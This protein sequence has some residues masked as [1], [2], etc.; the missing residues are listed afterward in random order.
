MD[1]FNALQVFVRVVE[2]G[3]FTRAAAILQLSKTTVTQ[4]VQQLEARLGV[5]LLQRTTRRVRVT[6]EGQAYYERITQVLAD[7]AQADTA[8]AQADTALR[9]RLRVDMP[10]PLAVLLV[11]PAL[12]QFQ[13][14]YPGIALELGVSD[15][16]IELMH[17]RVDCIVRGGVLQDSSLIAQR[18]ATLP[19][20]LYAAPSYLARHGAVL[21]PQDLATGAHQ[22]VGFMATH[23]GKVPLLHMQQGERQ[24]RV[25]A[26]GSLAVDDG[27]AC[28]AAL[29]AGLGI[30]ALPQYIVAPH[31]QSGALQPVL[32]DW[33]LPVMPLYVLTAPQRHA[34]ARLK[35]FLQ[36]LEALLTQHGLKG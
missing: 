24:A 31:L 35:A 27:N 34:S 25:E 8:L 9:G 23:S 28:L 7:L 11:V 26:S 21:Q 20:G 17:E 14:Q 33:Q 3:S 36:W 6:P 19:M 32:A 18:I 16:K 4:L 12:P 22:F 13:A 2:A 10:S 15:R 30:A 1:R 5:V 29:L